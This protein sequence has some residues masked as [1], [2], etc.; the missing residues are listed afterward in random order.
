MINGIRP[1]LTVAAIVEDNGRFLLVEEEIRGNL[2]INQPAG[3]V[4]A[5]ETLIEAVKRETLEETAWQ[6]EPRAITGIYIWQ[7]PDRE[8]TTLRVAFCGQL[9]THDTHRDLDEGIVRTLWLS[10]R[11]IEERSRS[12]RS[13]MVMRSIT[14]YLA[15]TRYPVRMFQHLEPED[16]ARHA[17]AV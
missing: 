3:H 17:E 8:S 5:N 6:F 4:E 11:E 13:P 1:A 14:D 10:R 16:L 2:V 15:G 9:I 12:L 7:H